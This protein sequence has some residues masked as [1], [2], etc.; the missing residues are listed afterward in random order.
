[1]TTRTFIPQPLTELQTKALSAWN[2]H[3]SGSDPIMLCYT[4]AM[5]AIAAQMGTDCR[6]AYEVLRDLY[7]MGYLRRIVRGSRAD[8]GPF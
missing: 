6:T 2:R 5:D 3:G 8:G 4:P 1:M 7:L